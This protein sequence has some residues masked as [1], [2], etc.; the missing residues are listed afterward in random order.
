[1]VLFFQVCE[2]S[3]TKGIVE[4]AYPVNG[5]KKIG[6]QDAVICTVVCWLLY[7]AMCSIETFINLWTNYLPKNMNGC[8]RFF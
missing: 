3:G 4:K 1:M 7:L 6:S 8:V 2:H 5:L